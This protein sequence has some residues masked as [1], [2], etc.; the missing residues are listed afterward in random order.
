MLKIPIAVS[1]IRGMGFLMKYH[2]EE[3]GNLPPKLSN[4]FI[5]VRLFMV[6]IWW[7][8]CVI[9]IFELTQGWFS[10]SNVCMVTLQANWQLGCLILGS[11]K[12][13]DLWKSSYFFLG[14]STDSITLSACF[15]VVGYNTTIPAVLWKFD[16][17]SCCGTL[18]VLHF[19]ICSNTQLAEMQE[20]WGELSLLYGCWRSRDLC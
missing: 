5:K 18:Q 16:F 14:Q 3:G 10:L 9:Q 7:C 2:M 6:S 1:G 4:L 13:P 15:A 17:W 19:F 11:S 12:S 20:V 8:S